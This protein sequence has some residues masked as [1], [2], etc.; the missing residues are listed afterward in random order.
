MEDALLAK[1]K[2]RLGIADINQDEL[3]TDLIL[4]LIH[5]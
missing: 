2:R 1:I 3:L 4:S 5:I